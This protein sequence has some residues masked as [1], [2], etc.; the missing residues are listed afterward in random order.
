MYKSYVSVGEFNGKIEVDVFGKLFGEIEFDG[1]DWIDWSIDNFSVSSISFARIH[2][3][4]PNPMCL[5]H[6]LF[7][8][9]KPFKLL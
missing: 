8:I 1:C 2:F 9:I 6:W 3:S 7:P 4:K 5:I